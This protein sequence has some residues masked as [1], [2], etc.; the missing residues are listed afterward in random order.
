LSEEAR[1]EHRANEAASTTASSATTTTTARLIV[2]K[3][4]TAGVNGAITSPGAF[5]ATAANAKNSAAAAKA[6]SV[7]RQARDTTGTPEGDKK[8]RPKSMR[9]AAKSRTV[10]FDI[11]SP[12]L[13]IIDDYDEGK[14][15]GK[16]QK[17]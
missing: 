11:A 13:T 2:L 9:Y 17:V 10:D 12:E 1:E 15:S 8:A 14:L 16:E 5:T 6:A 7:N 3:N 4:T